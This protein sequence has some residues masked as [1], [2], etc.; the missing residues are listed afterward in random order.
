M[1]FL[2]NPCFLKWH[3]SL[4]NFFWF[5]NWLLCRRRTKTEVAILTV[6]AAFGGGGGRWSR[7]QRQQKNLGSF[8]INFWLPR[9]KGTGSSWEYWIIYRGAGFLT[10]IWLGFFPPPSLPSVCS[11]EGRLRKRDILLTGQ[12]GGCGGGAKSYDGEKAWSSTNHSGLSEIKARASLY[13]CTIR[14][15]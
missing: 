9:G 3:N 7:L 12:G 13:L 2:T 10:V 8:F 6:L 15:M 4:S 1:V 14:K 11:K 5:K